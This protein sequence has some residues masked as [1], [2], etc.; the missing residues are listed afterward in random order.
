MYGRAIRSELGRHHDGKRLRSQ[1]P[2]SNPIPQRSNNLETQAW[3]QRLEGEVD[4]CKQ[5]AK[6]K[7]SLVGQSRVWT[8]PTRQDEA[9]MFKVVGADQWHGWAMDIPTSANDGG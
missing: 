8:V 7:R 1:E 9:P 3:V 2:G 4:G 6:T 5:W